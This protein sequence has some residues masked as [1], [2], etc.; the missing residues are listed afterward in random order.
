MTR[1]TGDARTDL[2]E[3]YRGR[4]KGAQRARDGEGYD[5]LWKKLVDLYRGKHFPET[6]STT[7]EDRIAV[8]LVFAT[9][10]VIAPSVAVNDPKMV[11]YAQKNEEQVKAVIVETVL[12]YWWRRYDFQQE[13]AL[14]VKDYLILGHGWMKVGWRYVEEQKKVKAQ[15]DNSLACDADENAKTPEDTSEKPANEPDDSA[16]GTDMEVT[17]DRPYAER[18]SPVD[19]YVDPEAKTL[20]SAKW[21]AQR[22]VKPLA[23]VKQDK[24]YR[25]KGRQS[26]KSDAQMKPDWQADTERIQ[27]D[28]KRCTIWEFYDTVTGTMC[29]F[30]EM[31]DD[32][33]LDPIPQPYAFGHPFV[34]LRNYE[35]PDHF[36][37]MGD[38]EALE[39]LQLEL[40]KVRSQMMNHRKRYNRKYVFREQDFNPAGISA[41]QA[42]TDNTLVPTTGDGPLN[43][44]IVPIPITAVDPQ[45]YNYEEGIQADLDKVSGVSEFQQGQSSNVRHTATEASM[46]ADA[47]NSR[48]ADKLRQIELSIGHVARRVVQLAQQYLTQ[49]QEARVM[50]KNGYPIWV[51][52]GRNEIQGEYDFTVEAGSTKP[53]NETQ[54]RN[55]AEQMLQTFTP[56][57]Q[58]GLVN[59]QE[60]VKYALVYGF[61]VQ[62]PDKF[63]MAA[64]PPPPPGE[65]QKSPHQS[66]IETMNYKDAP[67]D[68]QRQIEEKA[69]LQPSE[70]GGSS[71]AEGL[72]AKA[73]G[74]HIQAAAQAAPQAQQ[75]Q[76]Q[77]ALQGQQG[78]Q[79]VEQ[80]T[81]KHAH[82]ASMQVEKHKHEAAKGAQDHKHKVV[83]GAVGHSQTIQ[84]GQQQHDQA[85]EQQSQ[86]SDQQ[87]MQQ[88]MQSAMQ[89]PEEGGAGG[90]SGSSGPETT[91]TTD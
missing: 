84:Q 11:V 85:L 21:V 36:Y 28:V 81:Q 61:G 59:A 13:F 1:L 35:V 70:V 89:P 90:P 79:Q 63:M 80:M 27:D 62:N 34:M 19:I 7:D 39:P 12:N 5:G 88:M 73:A 46:I 22:L 45:L 51:P 57:A 66:L 25:Q 6:H 58:A 37:P 23:E 24:R 31:G 77:Q 86:G 48:A 40:D 76:V 60:L 8:N 14:A 91:A 56:Y 20:N 50:G 54:R 69:G 64:G 49:D 17:Q 4:V 65:G 72:V 26:L 2:L 3:R 42:D 18:V 83:E 53:L 32:F 9:I 38:V 30:P 55:Q 44:M 74:P 78:Q 16:E 68:I 75:A 33:L 67:P 10:N 43:D 71:P 87:M 52:Y 47:A 41:L 82:E 29:V 15:A